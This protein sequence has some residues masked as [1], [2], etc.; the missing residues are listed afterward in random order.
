MQIKKIFYKEDDHFDVLIIQRP[1]KN[2]GEGET[3]KYI[4]T[5]TSRIKKNSQKIATK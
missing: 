1:L 2:I 3:E 5:L 4:S